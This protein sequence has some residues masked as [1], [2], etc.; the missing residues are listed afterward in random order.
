MYA[1]MLMA[2]NTLTGDVLEPPKPTKDGLLKPQ[3]PIDA[4]DNHDTAAQKWQDILAR[5]EK[6]GLTEACTA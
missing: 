5:F 6:A 2:F 1:Q 4:I 3:E